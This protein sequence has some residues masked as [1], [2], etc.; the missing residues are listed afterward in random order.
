[1]GAA[2]P[3]ALAT[4]VALRAGSASGSKALSFKPKARAVEP[5]DSSTWT[6]PSVDKDVKEYFGGRAKSYAWVRGL[7]HFPMILCGV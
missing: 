6:L 7:G 1:M 5:V 4:A 2:L 3:T